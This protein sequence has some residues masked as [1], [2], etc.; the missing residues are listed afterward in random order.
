MIPAGV[1]QLAFDIGRRRLIT[2]FGGARDFPMREG[3]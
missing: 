1:G 3:S 2:A